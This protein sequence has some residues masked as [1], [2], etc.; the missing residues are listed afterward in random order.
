M[1][2]VNTMPLSARAAQLFQDHRTALARRTSRLFLPLF[3]VEYIGGLIIALY[4]TPTTWSGLAHGVHPHVLAAAFLGLLILLPPSILAI[5]RPASAW[6]HHVIA[7]GQLCMTGLLICLTGGVIETHFLIFG[8]LAFLA[9][10]RD[11]RVLVTA[12]LV[13]AVNHVVCGIYWPQTIY[14]VASAS[15]WRTGEHVGWVVF[16]DIFLIV[17]CVQGIR[18]MRDIAI[19]QADLETARDSAQDAQ[20]QLHRAHNL[21]EERVAARTAELAGA[22]AA[23]REMTQQLAGAKESADE[24]N[25]AKSRFLAN[26]SHEIRTPLTAITGYADMLLDPKQFIDTSECIE[27]IRRNARHLLELIN[28]ILDLSKIEAGHTTVDPMRCDLPQLLC[29]VASMMRPKIVAKGL[30]FK[31]NFNNPTPRFITTDPLRLRQILV[32]LIGNAAKFTDSGHITLSVSYRPEPD[33]ERIEFSVSDTGI[34]MTPEQL[35]RIFQPFT[36]ADASTTRRF[37]GTGLGLTISRKYAQIL[38]GNIVVRTSAG[39]GSVFTLHINGQP[40]DKTSLVNDLTEVFTPGAGTAGE[41][42]K[43]AGRVLLAEDGRDNRRLICAYLSAAGIAVETAENGLLAVEAARKSRF[44]VILMDMQMPEMDGY[45]AA[46]VLRNEGYDLPIVALTAHAMAE[47]RKKCISAGCSDYL[48]KPVDR[49]LLLATL[50][51]YF[52]EARP[53]DAPDQAP[54]TGPT[55]PTVAA[56]A[57]API[58]APAEAPPEPAAA[59]VLRSSLLADPLMADILPDYINSLPQQVAG[60]QKAANAGEWKALQQMAHQIKGAGGGYGFS[61]ITDT[62][63]Q[64]EEFSKAASDIASIQKS[65]DALIQTIRSVEGYQQTRESVPETAAT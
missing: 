15:L 37:G 23:L 19:R 31:L 51:F 50:A 9:F 42:N 57:P 44:D 18:E 25:A 20:E 62:A 16:T 10:Y 8:S 22:N 24:A 64:V 4:R 12:S 55:A 41:I 6:T 32:N 38:G 63:R 29:D 27:V 30:D 7:A 43:L 21:L 65:V 46:R 56:P 1:S 53:A 48:T 5:A 17:S 59:T 33:I 60:L 52:R 14:G 11:W 28:D 36:Q 45:T 3:L 39:E 13:T 58:P 35:A 40:V 2:Q 47:D 54:A 61:A 34:G 26:M 49:G